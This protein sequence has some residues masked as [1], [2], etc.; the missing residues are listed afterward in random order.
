MWLIILVLGALLGACGAETPSGKTVSTKSSVVTV[1]T[2]TAGLK[3]CVSCHPGQTT[4][5]LVSKHANV[6][7]IGNLFSQGNP[8][9]GQI[10]ACTTNCHDPQGDSGQLDANVTGNVPRPVVGCEACHSGG[11]MHAS[12]GGLGPI[13][14]AT[15]TAMVIGT[16]S[17]L[18]VSA[19]F[20]TCTG[21]HELLDPANPV[22]T[23]ATATHTASTPT[24]DAYVIADTHFATFG[25][26]TGAFDGAT[27]Q[28]KT[29]I[30]GYAMS[31][32]SETV[33]TDCH[34][35]H[36]TADINREWALSAHADK[37]TNNDEFSDTKDPLGYFS[38]A[39]AHYNWGNAASY[40]A[41]Q[42][43]H[44]TTGFGTYADALRTGNTSLARDIQL[45]L[46]T[47]LTSSPTASFKPE[48]L[49]CNGC[50]TDNKGTLRNPGAITAIYDFPIPMTPAPLPL[51]PC[52]SR[53]QG[54]NVAWPAYGRKAG[55][56]QGLNDPGCCRRNDHLLQLQHRGSSTPYLT[57]GG[58]SLRDWFRVRG[59]VL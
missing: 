13:G 31:F 21:C 12:G 3:T 49:K 43:C 41:C 44:T 10:G 46:V 9:L 17:S 26:F 34:N 27:G 29:N 20:R 47:L 40:R 38:G 48:M 28:G 22:N 24:G 5:W 19:Q 50:H 1:G 58:W 32:N 45:G 42:R 57:A 14:F 37:L 30:T 15:T 36:K 4:D 35:P 39:W 52:L 7:P 53:C 6:E 33:C 56:R 55:I 59:Q 54:S 25:D 2:P 18:P 8:K 51:F 11:Q 16:T 23:T